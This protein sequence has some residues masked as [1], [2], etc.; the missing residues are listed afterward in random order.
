M[1]LYTEL[2]KTFC[3]IE[4]YFSDEFLFRFKR[5]DYAI[6]AFHHFGLGLWIR[7]NLLDE[8]GELYKLLKS[9]GL[10]EKDSMSSLIIKLFYIHLK[11]SDTM[12]HPNI[13]MKKGLNP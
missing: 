10:P 1:D 8:G 4:T 13:T 11:L 6:L 12:A 9:A 7:N 2:L 5:Q 3:A